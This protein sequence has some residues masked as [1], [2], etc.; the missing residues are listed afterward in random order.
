MAGKIQP[1]S[2]AYWSEGKLRSKIR[3]YAQAGDVLTDVIVSGSLTASEVSSSGDVYALG[4]I[5][6]SNNLTVG[7]NIHASGTITCDALNVNEINSTS[8]TV[9]TLEIVDK[10]IVAAS[11][12]YPNN[13]GGSGL[14][15]G[16]HST[17]SAG[18]DIAATF[19]Y[20]ATNNSMDL[21]TTFSSSGDIY[22]LGSVSAS[23]N[24]AVGG[25]MDVTGSMNVGGN[26]NVSD[27]LYVGQYIY[28]NGDTDTYIRLTGDD[29]NFRAGGVNMMD[30]TEGTAGT[31]YGDGGSSNEVTFNEGGVDLDFRVES[32]DNPHMLFVDASNDRVGIGAHT[33]THTL[34]VAGTISSSGDVYALG[35]ISG[36]NNLAIGGNVEI[37]GNVGIGTSSPD[38]ELDVAGDISVDASIYHNGDDNTFVRFLDDIVILKAGGKSMFRG[39]PA[40]GQIYINNGGHDVDVHVRNAVTGTLLYTDAG[41]SRVGIGTSTVTHPLTVAGTISSSADVYALGSVS[42]SNNLAVGG[43]ADIT[44][45]VFASGSIQ[46]AGAI[47]A[48]GFGNS[49]VILTPTVLPSEYNCLLYGPVTIRDEGTLQIGADSVVIVRN[50]MDFTCSLGCS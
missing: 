29:I 41:N 43:N 40:A 24:L 21:S 12:T 14:Q 2:I 23:N 35:S 9:N 15:I 49:Q 28:H 11:G 20:N 39:D 10:V 8:K 37:S 22:S 7:G 47:S 45:S 31:G 50:F 36:S 1:S 16:G 38:Y 34:T 13:A 48:N 27:D 4:S 5:S 46:S 18:T 30:F 3:K 17:G 19:F 6:A 32:D 25:N 26:M 44:G 42:A 33:P